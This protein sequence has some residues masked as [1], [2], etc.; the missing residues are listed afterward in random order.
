MSRRRTPSDIE[1]WCEN[2]RQEHACRERAAWD[3]YLMSTRGCAAAA[4]DQAEVLAWRRL[5]RQLAQLSYDRRRSEFER[6]RALAELYGLRLA[7]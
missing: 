4:Y 2:R 6:D 1:A 5:R 7:S 3:E